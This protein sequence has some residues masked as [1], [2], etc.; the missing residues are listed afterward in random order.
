MSQSTYPD[1]FETSSYVYTATIQDTLLG[2][3]QSVLD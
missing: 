2:W 1:E 3:I